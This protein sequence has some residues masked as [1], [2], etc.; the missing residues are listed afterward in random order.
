MF[1][2]I[3]SAARPRCPQAFSESLLETLQGKEAEVVKPLKCLDDGVVGYLFDL[4][5]LRLSLAAE[6]IQPTSPLQIF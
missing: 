2:F 1:L 5:P 6:Q 4:V 3:W